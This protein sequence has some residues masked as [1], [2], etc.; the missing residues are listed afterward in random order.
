MKKSVPEISRFYGIIM[1][2]G[3]NNSELHDVINFEIVGNYTVRLVFDDRT[4]QVINFEPILYGP[5]FGPLHNLDVFNQVRL[6]A[7]SGT[8]VWPTSA[9]IDPNVLH[10]WPQHVDAIIKRRREQFLA[11]A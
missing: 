7:D 1:E 2:N 4:E 8:L 10:D 6:D 9:D 5:M 3:F 11:L